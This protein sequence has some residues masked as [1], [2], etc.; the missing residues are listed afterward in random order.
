MRRRRPPAKQLAMKRAARRL[1][2]ALGLVAFALAV[3]FGNVLLLSRATAHANAGLVRVELAREGGS[4]CQ[5]ACGKTRVT[6][7]KHLRPHHV[8]AAVDDDD[9]DDDDGGFDAMP[10]A[11]DEA[12][13]V[14]TVE[15]PIE[16]AIELSRVAD[17]H[18]PIGEPQGRPPTAH[19]ARGPPAA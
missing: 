5:S 14:P 2:A 19:L 17:V 13:L 12:A 8:G 7:A 4:G 10:V 9:D 1:H 11:F 3:L 18:A 6:H 16:E 15:C